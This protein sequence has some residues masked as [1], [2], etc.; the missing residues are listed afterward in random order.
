M[1]AALR[2]ARVSCTIAEIFVP[3]INFSLPLQEQVT[4]T[5]MNIYIAQ[6]SRFIATLERPGFTVARD[7]IHWTKPIVAH[8]LSHWR[9]WLN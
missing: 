8:M 9:E 1:R 4:L 2:A 3:T 6:L 5:H 7:N